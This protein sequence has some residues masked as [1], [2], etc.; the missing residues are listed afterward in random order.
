MSDHLKLLKQETE[1]VQPI[2]AVGLLFGAI[3]NNKVIVKK[4]EFVHNRL[5]SKTRFEVNPEIVA[6]TI[7]KSEKDGL[8]F[9]GLFHS[10]PGPSIPS[11]VDKKYMRLWGDAIWLI[12]SITEE[13]LSAY[14]LIKNKVKKVDIIIK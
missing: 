5:I 13:E 2:E 6:K 14:H 4:I 7:I 9:I 11:L 8:E 10:H 3:N 12:K 1:R